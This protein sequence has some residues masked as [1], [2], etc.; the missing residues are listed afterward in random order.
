MLDSFQV[1]I[2]LTLSDDQGGGF[3]GLN[4]KALFLV[5]SLTGYMASDKLLNNQ[6]SAY[7]PVNVGMVTST[8]TGLMKGT[9]ET[10]LGKEH[11]VTVSCACCPCLVGTALPACFTDGA[12]EAQGDDMICPRSPCHQN[13][14]SSLTHHCPA[15]T[16]IF[17]SEIHPDCSRSR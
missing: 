12:T 7:S 3:W 15:L 13:P 14:A 9:T 8:R 4:A 1:L 16:V 2:M 11:P 5:L 17:Q 6:T 10:H